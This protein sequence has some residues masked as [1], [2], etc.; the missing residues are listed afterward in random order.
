MVAQ[1]P[2]K[3]RGRADGPFPDTLLGSVFKG[4][5]RRHL[6]PEPVRDLGA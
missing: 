6:M 2:K 3:G 5:G 1:R 4:W